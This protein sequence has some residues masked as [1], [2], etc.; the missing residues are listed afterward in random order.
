MLLYHM[1]PSRHNYEGE[2][3]YLVDRS[4]THD[5]FFDHQGSTK[6]KPLMRSKSASVPPAIPECIWPALCVAVIGSVVCVD[7]IIVFSNIFSNKYINLLP[8]VMFSFDPLTVHTHFDTCYCLI[9]LRH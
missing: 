2:V 4:C 1:G 3:R 6:E 5:S 9:I 8:S 7:I